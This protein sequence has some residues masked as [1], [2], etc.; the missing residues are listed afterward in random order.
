MEFKELLDYGLGIEKALLRFLQKNH[1]YKIFSQ[2]EDNKTPIDGILQE[3]D[4]TPLQ[5]KAISP[6]I[7]HRDIG[8]KKSQWSR[9]KEFGKSYSKFTCYVL[10]TLYNPHFDLDY[11]LYHFDINTTPPTATDTNFVYIKLDKLNLSD[12]QIPIHFQKRIE[13]I[14]QQVIRPRM[15][16]DVVGA[17]KNKF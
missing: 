17:C 2:D 3:K 8:F 9:Y 13:I 7:Y 5:V 1:G 10:T 12:I 11:R 15:R 16:N 4:L 14:H 6:R